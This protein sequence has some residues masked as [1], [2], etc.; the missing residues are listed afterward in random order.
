MSM[1][2]LPVLV[3]NSNPPSANTWIVAPEGIFNFCKAAIPSK[4]LVTFSEHF[5]VTM[6]RRSRC[7]ESL[8]LLVFQLSR[9]SIRIGLKPGKRTERIGEN[10]F[11][12]N[13]VKMSEN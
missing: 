5:S 2:L 1:R 6:M 7:W 3:T 8:A 12:A 13:V 9:E 11:H 4:T 10:N